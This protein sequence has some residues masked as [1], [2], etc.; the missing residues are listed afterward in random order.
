MTDSKKRKKSPTRLRGNSKHLK[1]TDTD[2][3]SRSELIEINSDDDSQS[4]AF[5]DESEYSD[6]EEQ[7]TD[8]E[9][10]L[11]RPQKRTTD[12]ELEVTGSNNINLPTDELQEELGEDEAWMLKDGE[13]PDYI[14]VGDTNR[15]ISK[16]SKPDHNT[17]TKTS[18]KQKTELQEGKSKKEVPLK[19]FKLMIHYAFQTVGLDSNK[20]PVIFN[21][22]V[23]YISSTNFFQAMVFSSWGAQK[24]INTEADLLRA[25][26]AR[27]PHYVL[28][29]APDLILCL[30]AAIDL[31]PEVYGEPNGR[32]ITIIG[33]FHVSDHLRSAIELGEL[34]SWDKGSR[35][36]LL[37]L[38]RRGEQE[39]LPVDLPV[40]NP[41]KAQT[42]KCKELPEAVPEPSPANAV[43]VQQIP[44]GFMKPYPFR[45]TLPTAPIT[46]V[47]TAE[48]WEQRNAHWLDQL[49][50]PESTKEMF[51]PTVE[52]EVTEKIFPL[53]SK[54]RRNILN[55]WAKSEGF[56]LDSRLLEAPILPYVEVEDETSQEILTVETDTARRSI[57]AIE[58]A[59]LSLPEAHKKTA[60]LIKQHTD[61]LFACRDQ[62]MDNQAL[63]AQS[64]AKRQE[65]SSAPTVI[66]NPA[67][68]TQGRSRVD[69]A[70][71]ARDRRRS[72]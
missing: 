29:M 41:S 5:N 46:K 51:G 14:H 10:H 15:I 25:A 28:M 49:M 19:A 55:R 36:Q 48:D 38:G 3:R 66:T 71:T 22:A 72:A 9:R 47:I 11:P 13:V 6:N 35:G 54:A 23:K 57:R 39:P 7:M 40:P 16:G 4:D 52:E 45:P 64:L 68:K 44:T 62:E 56:N 61:R 37:M 20:Y 53:I 1:K 33:D 26:S 2:K 42:K 43:N 21:M 12:R 27:Y 31:R 17:A 24:R 58:T 50:D 18:V 67:I 8:D 34:I 32:G 30:I 59:A 65:S 60:A 63:M 69:P 70:Q